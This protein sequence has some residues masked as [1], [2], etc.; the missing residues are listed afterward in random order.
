MDANGRECELNGA[1]CEG[2]SSGA[3][4]GPMDIRM[5]TAVNR[6]YDSGY[7]PGLAGSNALV[8]QSHPTSV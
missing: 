7:E 6:L 2:R 5:A 4:M 3:E 1:T 8:L